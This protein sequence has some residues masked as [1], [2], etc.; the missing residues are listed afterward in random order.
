LTIQELETN[1]ALR[2][3]DTADADT[4][5][6][7]GRG[8][9]HLTVLIENMRREGFELMVGCPTVIEKTVDGAAARSRV[10]SWRGHAWPPWAPQAASERSGLPSAL[11]KRGPASQTPP[12][13]R[14]L[15][16]RARPS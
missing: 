3:D 10:A 5:L 6:V 2:V 11:V 12:R 1:V 14:G 15:S 16:A 13:G 7:S 9:L 8:L 4:V